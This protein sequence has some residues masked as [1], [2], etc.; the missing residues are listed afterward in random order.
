MNL[1]KLG[2]L[3]VI[4][5][6]VAGQGLILPMINTLIMDPSAGLLAQDASQSAR[7]F[8]FG[9]VIGVFYLSWFLGAVYISKLSDSIGRKNGILICLA[10]A[11]VGYVLT[12]LS[13]IYGSLWMMI[14]GRAITGF[15]SGNQPIAQASMA[16][17]SENE[18]ERTRN[19][20]YCVAAFSIGLVAGPIIAGVLSDRDLLGDVAS[21]QLPFYCAIVLVGIAAYLVVFHFKDRLETRA[22]LQVSPLD[23]FRLLARITQKPTVLRISLVFFFYMFVW[24]TCYVFVDNYLSSRFGMGTFGDSAILFVS[25]ATLVVS[26]AFLVS[27]ASARFS[28]QTIVV[29][30]AVTMVVTNTAFVLA[31]SP[32]VVFVAIVPLAA[33]FAIG[34]PTLLSIYSASVDDNEQGWVMGVA[35]AMWTL[36]AGLTS[37]IGGE[38]AAIDIE[39]PFI[40]AIGSAVLSLLF[41]VL[42]WQ[43]ADMRRLVR[44][45][46]SDNA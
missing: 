14:L 46:E 31:P 40:I 43:S 36:G 12:I 22:P 39:L 34:F 41:V 5:V 8:S 29:G 16:D 1:S 3:F 28:K 27:V 33:A 19:M 6:D 7:H 24:N 38:V 35:T 21:L 25:G 18:A 20:G 23:V 32:V 42:A 9:L 26:S 2:L 45:R 10:G 44:Q 17:I 15:T 4:F 13:I 30:A 11:F 37:L